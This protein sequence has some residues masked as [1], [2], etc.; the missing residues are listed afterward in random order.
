M[1]ALAPA[2]RTRLVAAATRLRAAADV[3]KPLTRVDDQAGRLAIELERRAR[4]AA[5]GIA[6]LVLV[7]DVGDR[8]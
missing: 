5:D 1:S 6:A 3:L 7:D 8:G 2:E 4:E